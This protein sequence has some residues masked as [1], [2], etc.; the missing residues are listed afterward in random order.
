MSKL[1]LKEYLELDR[2]AKSE[3]LKDLGAFIVYNNANFDKPKHLKPIINELNEICNGA[4]S[5]MMF[6]VPPQHYKSVSLL[7]AVALYLT[8]YP[9]KVVAYIS[10]SQTFSQTQTR[11]AVQIYKHFNPN[12][13]ILIDTQKEFILESGGGLITS[14]VDGGLTGYAIDW[15]I[16]D[17]PIKDRLEAESQ[18]F[19]NRN[20]DWFNDVAKTRLRP[21]KTSI[22][23]VHTRWHNNDLIGYLSKN[24]PSIKY[25]NLKAIDN[26]NKPLLHN[27]EF[28]EQVKQSNA[29]GF[30]SLYQGEPIGKSS[31]LF[32]EFVY[33]DVLPLNYQIGIGLDL[34]YTANSKSDYSVYVVIIKDKDTNKYTIVKAKCWQSDINETKLI[35]QR[36]RAE[37]PNVR[38][39]IEANG[40]QTAI[41]D[42][43][44]DVLK[45]L[46]R[47]ELK[48]DKFVRAQEFSS[49]WNLG[50]V[51]IYSKGDID[52]QF[53]EQIAEFSG[54]KDLHDDFIDASVYAYDIVKKKNEVLR[55]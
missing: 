24:E 6:S 1:T 26:D 42:M 33:T 44:K 23:I 36:L 10:Y 27:L 30:Y 20:I 35:L 15:L 8:K 39:A 46:N 45:P 9:H 31:H 2:Y 43:L 54:L 18:T 17:D 14:S 50:N 34:A 55:F 4:V 7:N 29:Y 32:K 28:Y 12:S 16:I 11:K 19:R 3:A 22:T 37:Y 40:T 41:Y 49:Q 13:K 53:F 21:D 48:G 5:K 51:L 25:I 52:N 38:M 47:V